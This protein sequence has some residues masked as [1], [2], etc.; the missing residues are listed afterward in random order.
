MSG[1]KFFILLNGKLARKNSKEKKMLRKVQKGCF[2][3]DLRSSKSWLRGEAA[4]SL[5]DVAQ[6]GEGLARKSSGKG[7]KE[8]K[9]REGV[10]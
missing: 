1:K 9:L 5:K 4:N 2:G 6:R 8:E 3:K 10:A 7:R